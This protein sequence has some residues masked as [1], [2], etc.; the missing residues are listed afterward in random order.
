MRLLWFN[1]ATDADD[2]FL[3]FASHWVSK[4]AERV[5]AVDVLTMRAGRIE[6]PANVRVLSVGKEKGYSEPRRAIEF[7]RI[8]RRLVTQHRYDA[9]FSHMIQ[10]F[11]IMAS[12]V[13]RLKRIP[14]VLWYAHGNVP[15]DLR[16]AARLVDSMVTSSEDGLRIPSPKRHI[17]GQGIETDHF[18]PAAG[19]RDPDRPFT[20]LSVGRL[21]RIKRVELLIEAVARLRQTH[22]DSAV[23]ARIVGG[24]LTEKDRGYVAELKQQVEEQHVQD[25]V[26]FEGSVPFQQIAPYYQQ[27]DCFVDMGATG[28]LDKTVLEAMSCAVPVVA[29]PVFRSVLGEDLAAIW[30][31][32]WDADLVY[33]RVLRVLTMSADA[34]RA[35][36]TALRGIVIRDHSLTHL[37][38]NILHEISAV[39]TDR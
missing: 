15:L 10:V 36:G 4:V 21:S 28:S 23:V 7:Y 2:P 22:P 13:L 25:A 39:L 16:V 30:S 14:I 18:A 37:C 19:Q 31:I 17:I 1:I 35:L 20:I 38:D 34:R 8:L 33:D 26:I 9:C 32:D 27:A 6:A 5:E 24:P 11:A 3:G 29:T 12:P